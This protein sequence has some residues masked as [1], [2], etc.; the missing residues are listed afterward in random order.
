M[1]ALYQR[2][3]TVGFI[4]S[5]C[6]GCDQT[7]KRIAE[8]MLEHSSAHSFFF[9]TLRLQFVQ[10]EGVLLGLGSNFSEA[11]KW[12][13]FLMLPLILLAV[14]IYFVL[15][16]RK[17]KDAQRICLSLI[18]GGGIGNIIDR[19]FQGSVTDFI[20]VGIG[21]LRT[22]IF[23]VADMAILFGAIGLI[24]FEF[25]LERKSKALKAC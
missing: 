9:D 14:A 8:R 15:F 7:T 11:A 19:I 22:G 21:P 4:L 3:L 13:F 6:I 2:I 24:A 17:L 25:W 12:W 10:N 18:V 5:I 20:N 1:T 23:N 16:S